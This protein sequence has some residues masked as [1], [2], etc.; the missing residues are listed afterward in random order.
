MSASARAARSTI[1]SCREL[2]HVGFSKNRGGEG[3]ACSAGGRARRGHH[4]RMPRAAHAQVPLSRLGF[5]EDGAGSRARRLSLP[6]GDR[7]TTRDIRPSARRGTVS[8]VVRGIGARLPASDH[9]LHIPPSFRQASRLPRGVGA[10]LRYRR[11]ERRHRVVRGAVRKRARRRAA[12]GGERD[13]D[14]DGKDRARHGVRA[15]AQRGED[16]RRAKLSRIGKK[17]SD[18]L[19][20]FVRA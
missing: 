15:A 10:D 11:G 2:R 13:P 18:R 12:R 8:G 4:R 19:A 14:A 6:S 3:E 17:R 16:P 20:R 7:C 9:A 5:V 1:S